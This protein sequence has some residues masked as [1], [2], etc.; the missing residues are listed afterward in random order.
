MRTVVDFH[1]HI[2]PEMDDGSDSVQTSLALLKRQ[3][4]QGAEVVCAT[5]HFYHHHESIDSF[6]ARR[7]AAYETLCSSMDASLPRV[8]PGAE[9]AFYAGISEEEQL[10][11]LYLTGTGT[12][13][14]E[15]PFTHWSNPTCDEV[16]RLKL[17]RKA[18]VVLAHPERYW[19]DKSNQAWLSRFADA[20]IALQVNCDTL[21]HLMT[22]GTGLAILKLASMPMLGTDCHNLTRRPPHLAQARRVI[23]RSLSDAFLADMDAN[24]AFLTEPIQTGTSQGGTMNAEK[25]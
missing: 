8:I 25:A 1:C 6:L 19:A 3:A 2:L 22:R 18:R 23:A 7:A 15:M 4:E 11:S 5:S 9:V 13:L 14:L 17:D 16:L 24:A 20:G 10:A 21:T 12:L